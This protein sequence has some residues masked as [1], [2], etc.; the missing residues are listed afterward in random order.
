MEAIQ[1]QIILQGIGYETL[2]ESFRDLIRSELQNQNSKSEIPTMGGLD[3]AQKITGLSRAS[4]YRFTST[5]SI[6]H[7][8]KGGK[9]FFKAG[10]LIAWIEAGNKSDAM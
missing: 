2:I 3:L 8:K 7:F 5:N 9:L 6:P 1:N 4:I 10:D